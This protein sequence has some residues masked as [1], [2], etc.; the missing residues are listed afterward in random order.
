MMEQVQPNQQEMFF[1]AVFGAETGYLFISTLD[2]QLQK[3]DPTKGWKDRSFVYPVQLK[4]ILHYVTVSDTLGLDVYVAAQLYK[5]PNSRQKKHVKA[6]PSAWSDLDTA[7]PYGVDPEPS[8]I[9]QTSP[10]RYHGFWR[11]PQTME[12]TQAEELSRRIAYAHHREGA[13]LGGWDLTQVLRVPGTRNQKYPGKPVVR[14][15]KCDATPIQW[16]AFD[17][18]PQAPARKEPG[19]AASYDANEP[20]VPLKGYDLEHWQK[21]ETDDR[22]G[23]A[24]RMVAIL[25]EQGLSDRLVEV[26]LANHPIYLAKARE[27]WGNKESLIHDDIR[28]CIQHWRDAPPIILV[29][30]HPAPGADTPAAEPRTVAQ[31]TGYPTQSLSELVNLVDESLDMIVD[32]VIFGNRL[33]WIF[34]PP[35]SGKTLFLLALGMHV[36]AGRDFCGRKVKQC[37]VL[38]IEEDSPLSGLADYVQMIADLYDFDLEAMSD[39]FRVNKVQG[40]RLTSAEGLELAWMAVESCPQFPGLIFVDAS[41]R[42][43]PSEKFTTKELDFLS[44]F[45]QRFAARGGTTGIIDHTKRPQML[46]GKMVEPE[47]PMELLYGARAKQ[48]ISDAMLY[49]SGALKHGGF[50]IKFAKFRGETPAD[51]VVQFDRETGFHIKADLRTPRSPTEQTVMQWLSRTNPGQWYLLSE[52]VAGSGVSQRSGERAVSTLKKRGWLERDNGADKLGARYRLLPTAQVS[53]E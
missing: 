41:E 22:S 52:I 9:L 24:M 6:C 36:A 53:F 45:A 39:V 15:L 21:S 42:V 35:N 40:L 28:R 27:K 50:T 51:V 32:G 46:K 7:S 34:S 25:K 1:R 29:P 33:H 31:T 48:A 8:I 10:G 47:D 16:K 23:W 19:E 5:E 4:D 13:D 49:L 43:V 18:M 14:M 30:T 38:F 20:P 26:A 17:K 37:P 3:Q 11:T 2:R 12:P 44:M